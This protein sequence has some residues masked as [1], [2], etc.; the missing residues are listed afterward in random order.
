MSPGIGAERVSGS[1][2]TTR[3]ST[4]DGPTGCQVVSR[5]RAPHTRTEC[6]TCA[7][8]SAI[9]GSRGMVRGVTVTVR[10]VLSRP[11]GPGLGLEHSAA[12]TEIIRFF[13]SSDDLWL[14]VSRRLTGRKTK[15]PNDFVHLA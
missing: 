3:T 9:V 10:M 13:G 6:A 8:G 12:Q 15:K 11:A 14:R 5:E 4:A 7:E 2:R 1:P